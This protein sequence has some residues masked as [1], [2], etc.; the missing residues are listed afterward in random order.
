LDQK[1][2][3]HQIV[4]LFVTV[5][6]CS[7]GVRG[8]FD[9]GNFPVAPDSQ[10]PWSICFD[11][12][13]FLFP[14]ESTKVSAESD[15]KSGKWAGSANKSLVSLSQGVPGFYSLTAIMD[16]CLECCRVANNGE[17]AQPKEEAASQLISAVGPYPAGT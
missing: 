2:P 1:V 11:G 9:L 5:L 15:R 17:E 4:L 12:S 7:C 10:L 14:L 3:K 8:L 6:L 13:Y 16:E